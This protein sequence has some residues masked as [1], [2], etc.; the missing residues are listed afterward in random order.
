MARTFQTPDWDTYRMDCEHPHRAV[1]PLAQEIAVVD[2]AL[3]VLKEEGILPHTTYDHTKFLA[4]RRA[5]ADKFEIPWTAI[6]P[7]M[8]RLLYAINAILQPRESC[9][10]PASS[11]GTPSS[12][13]PGRPW[14]RARAIR[15]S[16]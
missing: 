6:T 14:G 4:H 13:T 16:G 9:S 11:A 10:R 12:P 7:R 15:R 5:V 2:Q 8:Q 1:E 3:F